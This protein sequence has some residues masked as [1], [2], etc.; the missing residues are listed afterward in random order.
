MT[1]L[2]DVSNMSTAISS[3]VDI[4]EKGCAES[5]MTSNVMCEIILCWICSW[6][7]MNLFLNPKQTPWFFLKWLHLV[8]NVYLCSGSYCL[9]YMRNFWL[10]RSSVGVSFLLVCISAAVLNDIPSCSSSSMSLLVH[11]STC[12]VGE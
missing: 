12:F 10:V 9:M 5:S 11:V 7:Y 1:Y 8:V 3:F 4:V 2:T 6:N